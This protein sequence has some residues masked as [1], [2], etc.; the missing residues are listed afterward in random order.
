M[1]AVTVEQFRDFFAPLL[2]AGPVH[3]IIV[4][5]VELEA[6][7]EAMRRTVAALPRAARAP[8]IP[9]ERR[10]LRPPAPNPAAAHL[11][12]PGRSQPG[13][14]ADR[15]VDPR[16]HATGSASGARWRSP[17]TCSRRGCSTGCA[18]RRARPIRRRVAS[19]RRQPSR[20]GH[21]LRRRRDPARP[22]PPP[23]SASPARSSPTSPPARPWPTSS[24]GRTIRCVSGIERRLATNAYWIDALENWDRDPA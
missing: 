24:R 16:R 8:A 7:V 13:L 9:A 17:P 15:L 10:A 18:R 21:L 3:A 4:G 19:R 12:P 11:H 1:E 20:L 14:C 22:A 2:A 6:A 5:D 23:S